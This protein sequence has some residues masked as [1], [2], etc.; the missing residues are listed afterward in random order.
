MFVCCAMRKLYHYPLGAFSRQIRI[1]LK[2]KN[3]EHDL[4]IEFPWDM[5]KKDDDL[6]LI[7]DLPRFTDTDGIAYKGWYAIVEHMD[8]QGL[9]LLGGNEREKAETR[10]IVS[11]FNNM[12]FADVT[13]NI[14]FEKVVK[15]YFGNMS[16]D[17]SAIRRGNNAIPAYFEYISWLSDRRNWLAGDEFSFA[18]IVAAAHISSLD[19]IGSIEWERFPLV[20]DWY[21]RIK[22]RPSFRGILQDRISNI[23]PPAHYQ[24]LDF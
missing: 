24:D 7:S 22:S 12:F 11:L 9:S 14:V 19:Y 15:R 21:V 17:S 4:V 10:R 20:K 8:K 6:Q 2:E 13:K 18:D 3:V 16:P 1:Y 5:E 23:S